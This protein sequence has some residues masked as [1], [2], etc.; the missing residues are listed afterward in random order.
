MATCHFPLAPSFRSTADCICAASDFK[1]MIRIDRTLTPKALQPAIGR[2]WQ[3]SER[4]L[5]RLRTRWRD[6]DG[7]P[8]FT[9]KGCYTARGW[10]EWT[11]G[12]QF[13]SE[14]LQFAA[15]GDATAFQAGRDEIR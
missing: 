15:T 13:G 14:L 9:I 2:M 6:T 4:K 1:P 8:V 11:Q 5:A 12:F 3:V 10:T 7:A